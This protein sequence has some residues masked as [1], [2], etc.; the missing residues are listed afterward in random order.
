MT[1]NYISW[2]FKATIYLNLI[3]FFKLVKRLCGTRRH[4]RRRTRR[5]S[6]RSARWRSSWW[7]STLAS[8]TWQQFV[9]W[10]RKNCWP[11]LKSLKRWIYA[12][13]VNLR[14]ALWSFCIWACCS[15]WQQA[16]FECNISGTICNWNW[17]SI[18]IPCHGVARNLSKD[19]TWQEEGA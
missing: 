3:A 6:A 8:A 11:R 14:L 13:W 15:T 10:R 5:A 7:R 9:D 16:D 12:R 19:G 2:T 1:A 4:E 17:Y 18:Y